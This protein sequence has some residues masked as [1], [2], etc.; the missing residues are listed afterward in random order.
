[1]HDAARDG[2]ALLRPE[3][4]RLCALDLDLQPG[5]NMWAAL[6]GALDEVT[7]VAAAP[8]PRSTPGARR[9]RGLHRKHAGRVE[10]ARLRKMRRTATTPERPRP[11]RL[12]ERA[13]VDPLLTFSRE[14]VALGGHIHECFRATA[15]AQ[16]PSAVEDPRQSRHDFTRQSFRQ[17]WSVAR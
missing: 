16:R 13:W 7:R 15:P 12:R 17:R 2:H 9:R 10:V 11:A 5:E 3:H 1:V 6:K 4:E 14:R 8:S